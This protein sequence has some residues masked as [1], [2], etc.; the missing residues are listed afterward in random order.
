MFA[1]CNKV[2]D[3][4]KA[5]CK[6]C[7]HDYYIANQASIKQRMAEYRRDHVEEIAIANKKYRQSHRHSVNA[8][9]MAYKKRRGNAIK[10]RA[11]VFLKRM[12]DKGRIIRPNKCSLCR[13]EC[14][15]DGHHPD[16]FDPLNVIWLCRKCHKL[17]HKDLLLNSDS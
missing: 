2:N 10:R 8:N 14:K 13:K 17:V 4:R 16:Y 6:D 11:H 9:N 3:G 5:E 12:I 15:P 7:V 1:K